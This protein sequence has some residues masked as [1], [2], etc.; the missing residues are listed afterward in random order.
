MKRPAIKKTNPAHL[1]EAAALLRRQAEARLNTRYL[2][3][4]LPE[5]DGDF[6]HAVDSRRPAR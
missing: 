4:A 1:P 6:H 3:T 5:S 2:D